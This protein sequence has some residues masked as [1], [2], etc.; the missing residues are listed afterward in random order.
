MR[1]AIDTTMALL[2]RPNVP[3]FAN[4]NDGV[5]GVSPVTNA[6]GLFFV[7]VWPPLVTNVGLP[8]SVAPFPSIITERVNWARSRPASIAV[9]PSTSMRRLEAIE[10]TLPV[11]DEVLA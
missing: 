9:A 10:I 11:A 3:I 5:T 4:E 1:P 7:T 2:S 6:S 8:T